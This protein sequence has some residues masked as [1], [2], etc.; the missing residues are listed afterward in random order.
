MESEDSNLAAVQTLRS[1]F[2]KAERAHPGLSQQFLAGILDAEGV[3]IN[4]PEALLRLASIECEE[5]VINS[6][7]KEFQ[8]LQQRA[9]G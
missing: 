7:E 9:Q 6:T 5:Y 3:S 8:A 2:T 4:L 1:T